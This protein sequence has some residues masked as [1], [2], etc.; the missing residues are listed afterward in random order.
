MAEIGSHREREREKGD[1]GRH[2]TTYYGRG[3]MRIEEGRG[4][5]DNDDEEER[6]HFPYTYYTYI[7]L[8]SQSLSNATGWAPQKHLAFAQCHFAKRPY[9]FNSLFVLGS[10]RSWPR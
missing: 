2:T 10:F 6:E 3:R 7:R 9:V 5:D 4:N 1:E 8:F